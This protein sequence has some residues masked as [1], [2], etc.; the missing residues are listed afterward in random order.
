V[1]SRLPFAFRLVLGPELRL[2]TKAGRAPVIWWRDDDARGP[3]EPLD[4]LLTLAH[5]YQAPL[6]LA[7]I[8]GPNLA[9]LVRRI[10][11]E[12]GVE[13]AVHGFQHVN[14]QAEGQGFGEIV[15]SDSVQWVRAQLRATVLAFH[16]AG[17]APTLF[18]PP[19]NN[20]APQLLAAVPDTS[21]TAVSGFDETSAVANGV[22]RLDAH[23]D[24]LRWK[25]GGRFRGTWKFLSRMRRLMAERRRAG[26]WDEPI[27]LLTHHLDH[28]RA[29]WLFLEKFLTAFRVSSRRRLTQDV[30]AQPA[31]LSA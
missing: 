28:D 29:T 24:I 9:Q 1:I 21:I 12:P 10:E 13:I 16:R 30:L 25:G 14:R 2:W 7:A 8:A 26:R 19:W 15:E 18:T 4:R 17:A 23:L 11:A 22:A 27:G 5:L 20:L 3:T 31:A 6:T